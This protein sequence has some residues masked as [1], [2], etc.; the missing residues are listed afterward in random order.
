MEADII[1]R[2]RSFI[3]LPADLLD[4]KAIQAYLTK[5]SKLVPNLNASV[6]HRFANIL[7]TE[8]CPSPTLSKVKV[9]ALVRNKLVD[10]FVDG[11]NV[12]EYGRCTQDNPTIYRGISLFIP[13]SEKGD[14]LFTYAHQTLASEDKDIQCFVT[15]NPTPG[16]DGLQLYCDRI[17]RASEPFA[18]HILVT[19]ST[20]TP[21]EV[22]NSIA[23]CTNGNWLSCSI[24][25]AG[26][27]ELPD[28]DHD[29]YLESAIYLLETVI[30]RSDSLNSRFMAAL[31]QYIL[32]QEQYKF[33]NEPTQIVSLSDGLVGQLLLL[34]SKL[35]PIEQRNPYDEIYVTELLEKAKELGPV[36]ILVVRDDWPSY[37]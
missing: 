27:I 32:A 15:D 12:L 6:Y 3:V 24:Q 9:L 18:L 5:N 31:F 23:L 36:A 29:P 30:T 8:T 37:L 34:G 26:S 13:L 19:N 17:L 33:V 35:R 10:V 1:A 4:V 28:F 7:R 21:V 2:I 22:L 25:G 11:D 20:P 14:E 16:V